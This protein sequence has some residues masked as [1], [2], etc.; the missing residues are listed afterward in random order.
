MSKITKSL[1][2]SQKKPKPKPKPKTRPRVTFGLSSEMRRILVRITMHLVNYQMI[3]SCDQIMLEALG[4]N[5]K[6]FELLSE[7]MQHRVIKERNR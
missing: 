1:R 6:V 3:K 2:S 4:A 5:K 7:S